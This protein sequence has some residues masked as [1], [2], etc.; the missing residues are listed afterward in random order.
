MNSIGINEYRVLIVGGEIVGSE[1]HMGTD[2]I[3]YIWRIETYHV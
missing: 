2:I 1:R 3:Y